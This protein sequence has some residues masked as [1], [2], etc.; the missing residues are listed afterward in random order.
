MGLVGLIIALLAI[1]FLLRINFIFY[2]IYVVVGLYLLSLILTPRILRQLRISRIYND[3]AFLGEKV[4]VKIIC[5]NLSRLPLPWLEFSESVPPSLRL[6][7]TMRQALSLRGQQQASFEYAVQAGRRGYYRLG[8]LQL[9]TGDLFGFTPRKTGSLAP[10]YLT[11]YPRIIPLTRLRLPS[12]LPFGTITSQQRLFED[13]S[14]P[15]GVR[16][17]RSGDSPRRINW[18]VSAHTGGLLVKTFEPAISLETAVLLNLHQEDYQRRDRRYYTELAITVASSLAAHLVDQ[19]QPVG[20]ITNGIDPI[21][22][23]EEGETLRFDDESG[24]LQLDAN[25]HTEL[26]LPSALPARN[27]RIH[28]MK[29]LE[30]LARIE[31]G[32]TVSLEQWI[33]SATLNLSWG[34]TIFVITARGEEKT[35]QA[36]H[37]LVKAGY[38][39]F[40]FVVE[41]DHY[42]SQVRE[43]AR[44]LGFRAF[45]VTKVEDLSQWQ[46]KPT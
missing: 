7:Q 38:N 34:V 19:R 35:C 40:L 44:R 2:I 10:N 42:F 21:Q 27:G 25:A 31:Y 13:P 46:G 33:T 17:Y 8:P 6:Q 39:P 11:V 20:L 28:L 41:P 36:M 5:E 22:S 14:R 26:I 1:A 4:T 23:N 9:T 24:R 37:R 32:E 15:G 16:A 12:R 18:K 29:I 30:R 3:H 45:N 43:R